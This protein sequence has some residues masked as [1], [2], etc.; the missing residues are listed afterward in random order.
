MTENGQQR[1]SVGGHI[2]RMIASPTSRSGP[3]SAPTGN[4]HGWRVVGAAFLIALFG[5]GIGFYGPGIYLVALQARHGWSTSDIASAITVYYLLGATLVFFAGG[6]FERFGAR[7]VVIAGALA[8][9]CGVVLLTRVTH[10]WQIYPAFGV[11]SLG[12]A[13]M[14]GAAVAIMVAPWFDKRRGLAVSL[15][16]NGASAG[17]VVVAPLLLPL[18]HSLGFDAALSA[19][20]G[21]MLAVVLPTAALVLRRKRPDERDR[22]DDTPQAIQGS[23]GNLPAAGEPPWLLSTLLRS[24]YFQ[25]ISIPF[26]LGL[27]AQVGFL[28]HQVAFLSPMLGGIA[29]G[30]AVSLTT[31]SAM[32][33]RV[34]MGLFV[35]RLDRRLAACG[36]FVVQIAGLG[37]LAA[38]TS[39]TALHIGCVLFGLGVGNMI[40]LP[41]LIVQQEFPRPHFSRIV[42]L[43]VAINQFTFAFGPGLLGYLQRVD[44]GYT[45]ALLVCLAMEATAAIIVV[46]PLLGQIVGRRSG[47]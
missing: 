38:N 1:R 20:A 5:W 25:T 40:S 33:G 42:S 14:S 43:V 6:I 4:Y 41:A 31:F 19:A 8:M 10:P 7:L 23:S 18:I 35:D 36:N 11:M 9:A 13:A 27:L 44:G 32:V 15:A 12:W 26:A 34:L 39:A 29:A 16:L 47:T 21:V 24:G 46:L 17:G 30:W 45:T 2:G 3:A 37:F 22:A 28:T